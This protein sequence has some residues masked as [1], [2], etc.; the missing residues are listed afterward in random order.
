MIDSLLE[1]ALFD[2]D[3]PLPEQDVNEKS[4]TRWG[5]NSRFW[6]I[7]V[8]DG[9]FFGDFVSG[10]SLSVFHNNDIVRDR[11][12]FSRKVSPDHIRHWQLE[13][14]YFHDLAKQRAQSV[15]D[16]L[17][18]L[19]YSHP[20][21]SKK[22]ALNMGLKLSGKGNLVI[23]LK[24][25]KGEI[26]TLQ[27][28]TPQGEKF[29]LKGGRKAGKYFMF[30]K[31]E[32]RIFL[33]EGYATASSVYMAVKECVVACFDA[34]NL[35][36]VGSE[37]V[38]K[39]PDKKLIFCADNDRFHEYNTGI[40]KATLAAKTLKAKVVYPM[41]DDKDTQSTDFNDL[42]CWYGLDLVKAQIQGALTVK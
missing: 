22:K 6:A 20:Y 30:G 31:P 38:V 1:K 15:W 25:T 27:F 3:I 23:P 2:A 24:D 32:K 42:H 28:I 39:Y 29:Y 14:D 17:P 35:E 37:I 5:K 11:E 34:G 4:F 36:K 41:F 18:F 10:S 9:Y 33:C 13:Q 7:K 19:T 8:D 21:L 12:W 26:W 16:T 40:E